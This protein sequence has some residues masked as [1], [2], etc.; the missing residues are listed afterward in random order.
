MLRLHTLVL[1][2]IRAVILQKLLLSFIILEIIMVVFGALRE[3]GIQ[4]VLLT[5]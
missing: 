5:E 2:R 1:G 3:L 4:L